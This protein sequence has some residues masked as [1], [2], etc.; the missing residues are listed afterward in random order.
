MHK[1]WQ[2]GRLRLKYIEPQAALPVSRRSSARRNF[3][4]LMQIIFTLKPIPPFFS[5]G[6]DA[7]GFL[8]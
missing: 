1:T 4:G 3:G 5:I 6:D 8:I 7:L 2:T